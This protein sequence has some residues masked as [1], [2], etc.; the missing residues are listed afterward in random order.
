VSRYLEPLLTV[1]ETCRLQNRNAFEYLIAA[2]E[3]KFNRD[4]ASSLLPAT[5]PRR[6][7]KPPEISHRR[8]NGYHSDKQKT[9][10]TIL[11]KGGT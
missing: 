4:S 2:M 1:S 10:L 11:A 5:P 7:S 3:A 9:T 8:V 6:P